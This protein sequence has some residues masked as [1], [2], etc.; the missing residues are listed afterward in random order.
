MSMPV[1]VNEHF[2]HCFA[3]VRLGVDFQRY[4]QVLQSEESSHDP[5]SSSIG[6]QYLSVDVASAEEIGVESSSPLLITKNNKNPYTRKIYNLARRSGAQ[7]HNCLK[8]HTR[9]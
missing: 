5:K 1:I 3:I 8:N 9:Y 2:L 6:L 7:S 4:S